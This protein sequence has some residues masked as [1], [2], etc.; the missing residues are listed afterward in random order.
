MNILIV[1]VSSLGDVLHNLPIVWDIRSNYPDARID[2]V[3]E[4][5]YVDLIAPLLS[6][7]GFRGVDHLIPICLR[8]L[9]QEWREGG[10][11]HFAPI[12]K[13]LESQKKHLQRCSYDL[14][15]ETQGLLK[16]AII[17]S[18][19][20]KAPHAM[21]VGIGNRTEG[22]GYEPLAKL[23][24]T[25]RVKVPSQLHAVD[26][27]RA[28]AARGLGKNFP[29]RIENPPTFYPQEFVH[30]LDGL[31]N[32]LGLTKKT[33]VM[34]FHATARI[35]KCWSVDAWIEVAR[36]LVDHNLQVVLP[37]G[38]AQEKM[39]SQTIAHSVPQAL[40]PAPF[41]IQEAF[42]LNAQ[43]KLV[44]GVDTGL[45]HLGAVLG[46]PCIELYVDSPRWKTEGYWNPAIVN[47]G[48]TKKPPLVSEV[49]RK[50]DEL[51]LPSGF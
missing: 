23:F 46:V 48:D 17:T 45:T 27:S 49:L 15:I 19:A 10:W 41:S 32:P 2:W 18:L 44:I 6:K 50:M 43:A 12:M 35:A 8:R 20:K 31:S 37:W 42:I 13:S 4:E 1:K 47:L 14:V 38:N 11:R 3:V 51:L 29:I 9:R 36:Y 24:Y 5:S 16:S 34:C 39:R 7:D 22:S 40:V 33:Y 26:R 28:V 25:H 30:S 21:V